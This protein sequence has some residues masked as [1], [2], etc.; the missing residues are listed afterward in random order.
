[1]KKIINIITILSVVLLLALSTNIYAAT[2]NGLNVQTNKTT[3]KPGEEVKLTINFGQN[4]G[5]F[6]FNISYDK[7]LFDLVSVD[8]DVATNNAGEKLIISFYD[9]TGGSNPRNSTSIIFKAKSGITT[10]NSTQFSVT[11]AGLS[12]P[13]ASVSYDDITTPIVKNVTVGPETTT[14]PPQTPTETPTTPNE[15]PTTPG[16]TTKPVETP[17]KPEETTKPNTENKQEKPSKLPNTGIALYLEFA[18]IIIVVA[19]LIVRSKNNK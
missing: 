15:T 4:L 6:T 5:S 7:N 12:N 10:S 14:T 8:K 1:M 2:L 17:S 13:D 9:A 11:S 16:E 3:V 18:A 19:V